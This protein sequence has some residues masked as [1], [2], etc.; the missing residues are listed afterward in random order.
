MIDFENT[1]NFND[2]GRAVIDIPKI[3]DDE[4]TSTAMSRYRK[5]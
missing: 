3:Q 1:G 4:I 2:S 5:I